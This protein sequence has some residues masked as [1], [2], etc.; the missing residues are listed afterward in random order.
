[1]YTLLIKKHVKAAFYKTTDSLPEALSFLEN[2]PFSVVKDKD[3]NF[4]CTKEELKNATSKRQEDRVEYDFSTASRGP[5]SQSSYREIHSTSD[6]SGRKT[7]SS[8]SSS[9]RDNKRS[10]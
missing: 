5:I 6:G 10:K 9:E 3:G 8:E 4:Y 7:D 2:M 1:M